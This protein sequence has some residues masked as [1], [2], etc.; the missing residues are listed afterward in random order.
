MA[1]SRPGARREHGERRLPEDSRRQTGHSR[2]RSAQPV[3]DL[4]PIEE[5]PA[6][7]R[8]DLAPS[9]I[10]RR[11]VLTKHTSTGTGIRKA[12]LWKTNKEEV[13]LLYPKYVVFFADYAPGRQE[14]LQTDLRVRKVE[15]LL[16]A[17]VDAWPRRTT[18]RAAAT[19]ML[20]VGASR[21]AE[22]PGHLSLARVSPALPL[23]A[24]SV[25]TS[26]CPFARTPSV[27]LAVAVRRI[28]ALASA[29]TLSIEE[30]EKG[31]PI[32]FEL[33]LRQDALV[34]HVRRIENLHR[35]IS[36]W[37]GAEVAVNDD[38]LDLH[39]VQGV[40]NQI[41]E[42]A[43]CWRRQC[44][45]VSGSPNP[46]RAAFVLGCRQIR[47]DPA[48]G[49]P[50][51]ARE[52][53]AW[54]AVGAFDGKRVAL[55]KPEIL[56]Q[57]DAPANRP[58]AICPFYR[59]QEVEARIENLPNHLDSVADPTRWATGYSLEGSKS[60]WVFPKK[61]GH[62]PFGVTLT[63]GR[64]PI[65]SAL[66]SAMRVVGVTASPAPALPLG[67]ASRDSGVPGS[68]NLPIGSA[69]RSQCSL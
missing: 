15:E 59:R 36:R 26:R 21:C 66:E 22:A 41:G 3:T 63:P 17:R 44:Q 69:D 32:H 60:L 48:S 10:L 38:P 18:G 1:T 19:R 9:T 57:I 61:I 27:N 16:N 5:P 14:P 65:R 6:G 40:F 56:G 62:L 25:S 20:P 34:E 45:G 24:S 37:R 35:V 39:D 58:L 2:H 4:A 13:D 11:E 55:D 52:H 8:P 50:G 54:Y 33:A 68:A 49:F 64:D 30:D 29:G 46:C 12:L 51:L 42:I 28:K 67:T 43:A 23:P 31:R 53:P 47:L 7:A